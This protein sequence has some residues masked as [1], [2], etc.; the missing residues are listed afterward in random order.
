M[1]GY[2]AV[3]GGDIQF[4]VAQWDGEKWRGVGTRLDSPYFSAS[5][6]DLVADADTI[7][8]L[9]NF[10]D[11]R[12]LVRMVPG[13]SDWETVEGGVGEALLA[14]EGGVY[15]VGNFVRAGGQPSARIARWSSGSRGPTGQAHGPDSGLP[16]HLLMAP[17]PVRQGAS[18][19]IVVHLPE[20]APVQASLYD[21]LGRRLA[22]IAER[23]LPS[24]SNTLPL[25]TSGLPSGVYVVR[26]T[27]GPTSASV[28][29]VVAR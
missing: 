9:G 10:T 11:G 8:A 20:P 26:V 1:G 18:A 22:V 15:M 7:Y 16:L 29:V 28:Q 19:H 4:Q 17:S 6:S 27:A 13:A 2:I 3:G 24:G 5:L 12:H 23:T 25:D 14:D 21:L